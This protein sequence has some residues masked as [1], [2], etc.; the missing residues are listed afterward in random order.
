[1]SEKH[2]ASGT[3]PAITR[4]RKHEE[5]ESDIRETQI[6]KIARTEEIS[7]SSPLVSE[8]TLP[9]S[10]SCP[11]GCNHLHKHPLFAIS[12]TAM[13][14]IRAHLADLT[15][16][17]RTIKATMQEMREGV[18]NELLSHMRVR[19]LAIGQI[20]RPDLED[21]M[22]ELCLGVLE[23]RKNFMC[24]KEKELVDLEK[25]L[26]GHDAMLQLANDACV[27]LD[28]TIE[29]RMASLELGGDWASLRTGEICKTAL[30]TL[31]NH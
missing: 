7:S 23:K 3:D 5:M 27:E 13:K 30:R 4:K 25:L 9:L 17:N 1:M 26:G 14:N 19:Q 12:M 2:D 8:V 20:G 22:R 15:A 6:V 24:E 31:A 29:S 18:V 11:P 28:Q 16:K 10:P 21:D